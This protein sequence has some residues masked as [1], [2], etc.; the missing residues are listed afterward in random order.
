[1]ARSVTISD[2]EVLAAARRLLLERG[3][4]V[5]VA[6]IA[7]SI[8]LS[9]ATIFQRFGSKEAL[10][11]EA[12]RPQAS[13][14]WLDRLERPP[15]PDLIE[16]QLTSLSLSL[17]RWF[18]DVVPALAVLRS[19]GHEPRE[20]L[21]HYGLPDPRVILDALSDWLRRADDN[22]V[23]RVE[24]AAVGA[25]AWLGA[26]QVRSLMTYLSPTR[27]RLFDDRVYAEQ[28][29]AMLLAGWSVK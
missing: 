8:G 7:K 14:A 10:V 27:E 22:G 28:V 3:H 13:M 26:V 11:L 5:T 24:D 4:R 12:L 1:M 23:I 19:A 6:Q 15:D 18:A 9:D 17:G 25:M 29:A 16:R 20:V 21:A 2:E